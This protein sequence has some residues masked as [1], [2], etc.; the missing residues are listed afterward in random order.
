M[1]IPALRIDDLVIPVRIDSDHEYTL[2]TA[3]VALGYGVSDS[4]IKEH[5]RSHADELHEGRHFLEVRNPDFQPG[6]GGAHTHTHWTKRGIVRL[7]FFIRSERA[8]RFRDLAEDLI[9][10]TM[11]DPTLLP[12]PPVADSLAR[13]IAS[14]QIGTHGPAFDLERLIRLHVEITQPAPEATARREIHPEIAKLDRTAPEV[15]EPFPLFLGDYYLSI[16]QRKPCRVTIAQLLA[17]GAPISY[18]LKDRHKACGNHL[19]HWVGRAFRPYGCPDALTIT[20]QRTARS[21]HYLIQP[22]HRTQTPA[23]VPGAQ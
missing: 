23:F 18:Q 15:T 16:G 10:R 13:H 9:I 4:A 8:K 7:G 14:F 17:A 2:T 20:R 21:R 22:Y 1:N 3:E 5:K 11:E 19:R 12:V 6:K